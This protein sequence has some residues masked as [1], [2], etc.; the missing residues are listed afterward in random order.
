[1]CDVRG[2]HDVDLCTSTCDRSSL[3]VFFLFDNY[4][5]LEVVI[6]TSIN[7]GVRSKPHYWTDTKLAVRSAADVVFGAHRLVG[8]IR[9]MHTR[10]WRGENSFRSSVS[11]R[12]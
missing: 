7:S 4:Y 12:G 3:F 6:S 11:W 8:N 9:C 2:T 5:T 1:M 10:D